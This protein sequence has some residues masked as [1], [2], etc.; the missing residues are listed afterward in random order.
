MIWNRTPEKAEAVA[1]R[2]GD[3][4]RPVTVAADLAKAVA[5]ADIVSCAVMCSDPVLEGRWLKPGTHVD[6]VGAYRL[7]MREADDEV[8]RRGRIF[9]NFR[10]TTIGHIGEIEIPLKSGVIR[11]DDILAD[12]YDLVGAQPGRRAKDEITVY[13]NGGG[14]HLDLMTALAIV[15]GAKSHGAG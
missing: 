2:F 11:K 1:K 12:L 14:A 13:K 15:E 9:V 6:L 8:M 3:L 5:E 7:D 10:G 4:G